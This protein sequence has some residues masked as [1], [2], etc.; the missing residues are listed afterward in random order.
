MTPELPLVEKDHACT[1]GEHDVTH[2]ELDA[3]LIP[4]ALRHGAILG[5]LSRV[6]PGA[7][8]VLV[9]P[10][11]PLPLLAEI[12]REENGAIE[13]SYLAEGPE[14]WRLLLTRAA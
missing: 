14:A 2:P 10:H 4:H 5:A 12:E 11:N 9:A 13:V 1:C 7:A 3:R 6:R 8:M